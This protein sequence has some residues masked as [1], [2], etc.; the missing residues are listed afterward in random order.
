M[1][2]LHKADNTVV[3]TGP[4][5]KT[6]KQPNSPS[7]LCSPCRSFSSTAT[8]S[9]HFTS[10]PGQ[11]LPLLSAPKRRRR[12]WESHARADSNVHAVVTSVV[13]RSAERWLLGPNK[14]QC[15]VFTWIQYECLNDISITLAVCFSV[16]RTPAH[17]HWL[18]LLLLKSEQLLTFAT[19]CCLLQARITR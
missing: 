1:H 17:P 16:R 19:W 3:N 6:T 11:A 5:N 18:Q 7:E 2:Y 4:Y 12:K 10:H 8:L 15:K 13:R 9:R 14:G